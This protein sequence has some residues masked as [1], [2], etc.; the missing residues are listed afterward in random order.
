MCGYRPAGRRCA[1]HAGMRMYDGG[2]DRDE[3]A[4]QEDLYAEEFTQRDAGDGMS[5]AHHKDL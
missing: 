3:T 2:D 1:L 5:V 4:Q